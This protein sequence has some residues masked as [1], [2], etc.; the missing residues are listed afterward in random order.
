M[1]DLVNWQEIVVAGIV[2]LAVVSLYRHVRELMGI[3]KPSTTGGCH[4]CGGSDGCGDDPAV[5]A[6]HVDTTVPSTHAAD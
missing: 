3:A 5:G 4:G 1:G 6:G 2:A